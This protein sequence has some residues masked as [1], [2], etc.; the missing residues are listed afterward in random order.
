[1]PQAKDTVEVETLEPRGKASTGGM[2]SSATRDSE[3]S[4]TRSRSA[5]HHPGLSAD[6]AKERDAFDAARRKAQAPPKAKTTSEK[7]K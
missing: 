2:E 4:A 5:S 1:M 7:A 6:E 3:T